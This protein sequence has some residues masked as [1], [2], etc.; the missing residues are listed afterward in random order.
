MPR[1]RKSTKPK[2]E[3]APKLGRMTKKRCLDLYSRGTGDVDVRSVYA[4]STLDLIV[5]EVK[6]V[7]NAKDVDAAEKVLEKAKYGA[8]RNIAVGIREAAGID[9]QARCPHCNHV[10]DKGQ[11]VKK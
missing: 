9:D 7:C 11:T 5:Q 10:L 1:G 4:D 2:K 3:E 6:D 8:P